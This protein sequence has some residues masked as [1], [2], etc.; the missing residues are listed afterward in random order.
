M[1]TWPEVARPDLDFVDYYMGMGKQLTE[2]QQN[3]MRALR[4]EISD[5]SINQNGFTMKA[6]S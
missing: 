4:F 3:S 2:F 1:P 6:S 5:D